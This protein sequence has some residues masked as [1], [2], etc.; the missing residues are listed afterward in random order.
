MIATCYADRVIRVKTKRR[1][2][3]M[4][5]FIS[6]L[7]AAAALTVSATAF[8]NC[9]TYGN[10][11]NCYDAQS[12]NSYN[13]QTYGDTSITRGSNSRTGSSWS[14]K[15]N[16]VGGSTYHR[17]TDSDGDS[18]RSREDHYDYDNGNLTGD[19][20]SNCGISGCD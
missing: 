3:D 5:R 7:V 2:H 17:G 19:G 13:T 14:Q 18:W 20:M 6:T 9:T 10:T 11:T 1:E 8:A 12:G 16:T 4:K 15:S